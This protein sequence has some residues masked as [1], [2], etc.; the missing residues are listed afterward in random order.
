MRLRGVFATCFDLPRL[1]PSGR[2]FTAERGRASP[3]P[4]AQIE[5]R[6]SAGR[7]EGSDTKV[8]ACLL[9]SAASLATERGL[10]GRRGDFPGGQGGE[11]RFEAE[12]DVSGM[13]GEL[14]CGP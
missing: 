8:L 14:V 3:A 4:E 6:C 2:A 10:G 13:I 11:G 12:R 7:S 9:L 1:A 5:V